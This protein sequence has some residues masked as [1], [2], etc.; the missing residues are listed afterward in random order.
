MIKYLSRL[1]SKYLNE[2]IMKGL[3]YMIVALIEE[4]WNKINKYTSAQEIARF[5][6]NK[7]FR[8][9]GDLLFTSPKK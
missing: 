3:S 7:I 6:M 4:N 9:T 1:L 2:P 5:I 8:G